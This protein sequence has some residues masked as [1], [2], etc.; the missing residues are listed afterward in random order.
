MQYL[1]S[2]LIKVCIRCRCGAQFC[3]TCGQRW[4]TCA[5][6]RWDE[7]RLLARAHQIVDREENR[8]VAAIARNDE[9][10]AT[11]ENPGPARRR[12]PASDRL[13]AKTMRYLRE[14]HECDHGRW[15]RVLGAHQCEECL[16]NLPQYILECRQCRIRA[17]NRCKWNRL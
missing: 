13:V 7:H 14:N 17:C 3:Y 10:Q 6:A 16:H 9:S 4:K 11:T 15:R 2:V 12:Q 8:L 1:S 5:C